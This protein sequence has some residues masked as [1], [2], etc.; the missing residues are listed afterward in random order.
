MEC[1]IV[2][3]GKLER[4]FARQYV[5]TGGFEIII[6]VDA[7]MEQ[8]YQFGIDPDIIVGDFDSVDK[9]VLEYFETKEHIEIVALNAEKDETDTESA[10]RVAL[11]RGAEHIVLIGATGTRIDHMLGNVCL[12]GIGLEEQVDME[13][14][15]VNNR[16]RLI[17]ST[18]TISQKEQYGKYV[19][20][21]PIFGDARGV[22]LSGM[23]YPLENC[24]M[25]TYNSLG[26]SNEIVEDNA[27]ITV[28]YGT[29]LVIESKD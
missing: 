23:K 10:I 18:L 13:I 5:L 17:D 12:L 2:S 22:S 14:V 20:V 7:G 28:E 19:S 21:L 9:Q 27:T 8:L 6:A 25:S 15:D 1:L 29:L 16:I 26:V 11:A 4:E 24:L 3:G